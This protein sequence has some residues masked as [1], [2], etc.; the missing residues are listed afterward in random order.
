[1]V[2]GVGITDLKV[3]F[4]SKKCKAYTVWKSMLGR[5]YRKTDVRYKTYG[6]AGV[7]VHP[8]WF[9][10]SNFKDW[11]DKNYVEGF[12]LDKDFLA[13]G[14]KIYSVETCKFVSSKENSKEFNARRDN[15]YLLGSK[16]HNSKPKEHYKTK[17]TTIR[18]FKKIC[19]VQKW[20]FDNFE[21]T[22]ISKDS[23]KRHKKWFFIEKI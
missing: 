7:T 5:C 21:K 12:Q 17:G 3:T 6:G 15:A 11:F 14:N 23:S 18:D 10:F 13:V 2:C 19:R 9:L 16:H 8:S 4:G 22:E 20:N 1:M